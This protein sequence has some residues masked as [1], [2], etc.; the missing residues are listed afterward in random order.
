MVCLCFPKNS[1]YLGSVQALAF[2]LWYLEYVR[3][4]ALKKLEL[5]LMSISLSPYPS[6]RHGV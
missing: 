2:L 3:M 5:K 4:H 1:F 6:F